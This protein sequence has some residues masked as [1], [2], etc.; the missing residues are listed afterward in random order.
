[1]ADSTFETQLGARLH[2]VL[3]SQEGPHPVWADA[4]A[5]R[6][7][8]EWRQR[9]DRWPIRLLGIAAILAIGGGVVSIAGSWRPAPADPFL[10]GP[11]ADLSAPVIPA[12]LRGQFVGQLDDGQIT[13][14]PYPFYFIDLEDSVLM[15]GP[16][17]SDNPVKLRAE[18]GTSAD[19]AGRIVEFTRIDAGAAKVVIQAP[20]PCGEG[21]YLVRYDEVE[22]PNPPFGWILRF[23]QPDDPCRDRVAILVGSPDAP[24]RAVSPSPDGSAIPGPDGT[25]R[26][27]THQPIELVAG[28]RY[29]SGSFTEPF[30]F[31]MPVVAAPQYP[32]SYA[33]TWLPT[34]LRLNS[35]WW[36]SA[37][38]DDVALP[39]CDR[40]LADI[41]STPEAFES[42]LRSTGRTIERTAS[43]VVDGR[44][45]VRYDT[46]DPSSDCPGRRGDRF[47][48]RW[49][50]IPTGDDTILFNIYGDT[51]TEVQLA[52]DIVRS[53]TFD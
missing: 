10:P 32:S 25:E 5:A 6:L 38:Y 41:P 46:S 20:P 53:M 31:R 16:G 44:T 9:R 28:E 30:H 11:S 35:P 8:S 3:D 49:Y 1:M 37:F 50:L 40:A 45:A 15:H 22:R 29:S 17:D 52:D 24:T 21:R 39:T 26:V 43:L 13:A 34:K 4:P 48:G 47:F 42:W 36:S 2:D 51:E 18:S 7:A 23:T 14:N 19:W 27:W 33:S 12:V